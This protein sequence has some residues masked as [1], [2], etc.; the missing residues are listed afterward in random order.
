[1]STSYA[2]NVTAGDRKRYAVDFVR[3]MKARKTLKDLQAAFESDKPMTNVCIV[4]DIDPHWFDD[5]DSEA[6]SQALQV[7][8][9]DLRKQAY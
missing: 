2:P 6:F 7:R 8:I 3:R 4:L 1:M 9:A 5:M